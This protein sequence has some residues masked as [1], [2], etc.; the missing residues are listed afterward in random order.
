[1]YVCTCGKE[2]IFHF[3]GNCKRLISYGNECV[4]FYF[5]IF[6]LFGDGDFYVQIE[7]IYQLRYHILL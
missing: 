2:A 7:E 4:S 3:S 6:I 5:S 1:M